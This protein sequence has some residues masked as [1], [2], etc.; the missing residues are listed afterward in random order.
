MYHPP[1]YTETFQYL[2]IR[3]LGFA[4]YRR[5]AEL[6]TLERAFRG[7]PAFQ[8]QRA[9]GA[10]KTPPR[11]LELAVQIRAIPTMDGSFSP[12]PRLGSDGSEDLGGGPPSEIEIPG[13]IQEPNPPD[14]SALR[15]ASFGDELQHVVVQSLLQRE[16]R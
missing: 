3:R 14:F 5:L 7:T 1:A 13:Q 6:H 15:R 12:Q 8:I 4:R 2:L 11:G 10:V 16:A 9:R